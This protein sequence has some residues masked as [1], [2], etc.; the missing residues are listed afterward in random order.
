VKLILHRKD[1][2]RLAEMCH[3]EYTTLSGQ[4]MGLETLIAAPYSVP[5]SVK[6]AAQKLPEMRESLAWVIRTWDATG[7]A[8]EWVT[9]ET[10]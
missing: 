2:I 4:I 1:K 7:L 5:A 9:G 10:P 8:P 6:E 3:H